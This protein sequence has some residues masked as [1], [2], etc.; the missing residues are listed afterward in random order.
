MT[1]CWL[2]K[3]MT[4][5][6]M[7]GGAKSAR[8]RAALCQHHS[9]LLIGFLYVWMFITLCGYGLSF[10]IVLLAQFPIISINWQV[11]FQSEAETREISIYHWLICN[12][13][14][15]TYKSML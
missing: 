13:N 6:T 8:V 10:S 14:T 12:T 3:E 9:A 15:N 2:F 5:H 11:S 4:D 7:H 1:T